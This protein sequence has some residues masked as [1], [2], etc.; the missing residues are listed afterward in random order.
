M[1][2]KDLE[3]YI[4]DINKRLIKIQFKLGHQYDYYT[5]ELFL[6]NENQEYRYQ[7][8]AFAGSKKECYN[9]VESFMSVLFVS[10]TE[11]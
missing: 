7:S 9:F 11:I 1:T 8:I 3:N 4:C 2:R 10:K 5:I 6:L